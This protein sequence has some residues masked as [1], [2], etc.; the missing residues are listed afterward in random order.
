M[1]KLSIGQRYTIFFIFS[2]KLL[3]RAITILKVNTCISVCFFFFIYLFLQQVTT[4]T[5]MLQKLNW[6]EKK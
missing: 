2:H 6:N 4:G 1:K 3:L 5:N